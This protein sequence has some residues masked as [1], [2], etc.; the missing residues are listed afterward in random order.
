LSG[1]AGS[2]IK[3]EVLVF[4]SQADGTYSVRAGKDIGL[5]TNVEIPATYK[6]CSVTHIEASAFS[7]YSNI[8][9]FVLPDTITYIG[10]SAFD[11]C[12]NA[13]F[14]G[15]PA[16]VTYIGE[17]AFYNCA[18]LE[19]FTVPAAIKT[20][21]NRAFYGCASATITIPETVKGMEPYALSETESFVVEG[22]N[23]WT[24]KGLNYYSSYAGGSS[25]NNTRNYVVLEP[26]TYAK[27]EFSSTSY[28]NPC[29]G[30]WSRS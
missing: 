14:N 13:T 27:L 30:T 21:K 17:R 7:G 26:S 15:I 4:T 11:G 22:T 3:D 28:C 12:A 18:K 8:E 10:N 29:S 19:D 1:I 16:G 24:V 5:Y 20:L 9:S 23:S 25:Y 6:G 2:V